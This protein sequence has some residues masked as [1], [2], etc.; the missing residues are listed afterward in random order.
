MPSVLCG[1]LF[2]SALTAAS[3]S[4]IQNRTIPYSACILLAAA[5]LISFSP[6]HLFGLILA[7]PFFLASGL[8]RGGAGDTMLVA[9]ASLT[10]GFRSGL[11][12]L[13]LSL[14]LFLLFAAAD[15]LIRHIRNRKEAPQSY[16]LA[17]FL[18]TGFIAAFF[19]L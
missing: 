19:I 14:L 4:D 1:I 12:G 7:A 13:V 5:G 11:A 16:P 6:A 3:V 17:P 9:A 18:S 15:R 10:L 2:V 8:G